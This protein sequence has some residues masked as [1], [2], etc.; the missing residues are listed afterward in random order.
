MKV[1]RGILVCLAAIVSAGC[2]SEDKITVDDPVAEVKGLRVELPCLGSGTAPVNCDVPDVDEKSSVISGDEGAIYIV[3]IRLRGVVEQKTYSDYS[4]SDG[5][6]IVGGTPDGGSWN[7]FRLQ[8]SDPPQTYHMNSG[9]SGFDQC[10]ELDMQR[11]IRMAHG[12]TLTL[13]AD[14]GGDN[15]GTINIDGYDEP[16]VISGVPPYPYAFDGQFVQLDIVDVEIED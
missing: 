8:V 4:E 9:A 13:L 3:T 2:D 5:M 15:L 16:I 10:W 11:T 14:S 7:I 1:I 12:A 6:W